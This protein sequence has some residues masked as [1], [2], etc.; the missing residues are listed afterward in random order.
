[1]AVVIDLFSCQVVDWSLGGHMTRQ[2]VMGALRVAWFRR[3][4][5]KSSG[6]IFHSD[7]LNPPST[8][9]PISKTCSRVTACAVP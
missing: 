7:R 1:M 8:A 3:G 4:P 6:L 2:L 9:A 5:D